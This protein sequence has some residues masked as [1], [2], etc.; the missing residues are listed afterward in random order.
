ML[1]SSRL[2]GRWGR[3]CRP[4]R[5]LPQTGLV[6]SR[7]VSSLV[8]FCP[9]W[10]CLASQMIGYFSSLA[11]CYPT[12]SFFSL[13]INL[14]LVVSSRLVSCLVSRLPGRWGRLCRP[15]GLAPNRARLVLS[16]VVSSSRPVFSLLVWSSSF[17]SCLFFCL[18]SR[19]LSS[20]IYSVGSQIY[21]VGSGLVFLSSP[22]L[23][24]L[25]SCLLSSKIYS[26]GSG[27]VFLSS[28]IIYSVGSGLVWSSRLLFL[29]SSRLRYTVWGGFAAPRV[30]S[31]V[32]RPV[33]S[34]S[35]SYFFSCRLPSCLL[36]VS[37]LSSFV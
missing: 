32:S 23:S 11:A 33:L 1:A 20:Q 8:V 5:V 31:G 15:T 30:W 16:L 9:V 34:S 4:P 36:V 21:S 10:S 18:V 27:L 12:L 14:F 7:L 25:S 29:V 6:S 19:L 22:V 2:P 17:F 35:S 26:V 13:F 28:R 3:L 24:C 37:G